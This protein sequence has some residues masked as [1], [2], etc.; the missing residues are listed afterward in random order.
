MADLFAQFDAL[1]RHQTVADPP[2]PVVVNRFLSSDRD[3]AE[4]A[5]V[6]VAEAALVEI[7]ILDPLHWVRHLLPRL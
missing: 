7:Q 5:A 4:V 6:V 2:H 3:F 1:F